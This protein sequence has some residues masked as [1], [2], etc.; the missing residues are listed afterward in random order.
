MHLGNGALFGAALRERRPDLPVPP[1]LRGPLAGLAEH[2][3]D[4]A[5]HR[6]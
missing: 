1:A 5:R 6:A 2:L 4:L 3:R